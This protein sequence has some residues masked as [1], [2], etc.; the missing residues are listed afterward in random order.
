MA[1]WLKAHAWKACKRET[2]SRVRIPLSPPFFKGLA[3]LIICNKMIWSSYGRQQM[4]KLFLIL[5]LNKII[6]TNINL[7]TFINSLCDSIKK[8]NGDDIVDSTY[9][10]RK[11]N[12]YLLEYINLKKAEDSFCNGANNTFLNSL[13]LNSSN[14]PNDFKSM[15]ISS[16]NMYL[17]ENKYKHVLEIKK[18]TESED[19]D[20]FKGNFNTFIDII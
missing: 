11:L 14:N 2:V 16:L 9:L 15:Y 4:K 1:E 13:N 3:Q 8:N 17:E 18:K 5:I 20:Y 6:P 7:D 10:V 12:S 19:I